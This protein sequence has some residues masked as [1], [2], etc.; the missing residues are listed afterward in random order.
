MEQQLERERSQAKAAEQK[1]ATKES[2]NAQLRERISRLYEQGQSSPVFTQVTGL[3]MFDFEVVMVNAKG[4]EVQ[5]ERK[6]AQYDTED[7]GNDI[8]LE[9]VSIPGGKFLM[10]SPEG[11]KDSNDRE[12]PQHEVTVP[13]FFMGKYLI[14]QAQWRAIAE[15]T[16]L[17]VER[18][19]DPNPSHFKGDNR[20]VE[21]VNWYEA[22]E[23]CKR[24]SKLT[25]RKYS[26]PSE[27]EWEYACRSVISYQSRS[28]ARYE[29]I[30]VTSEELTLYERNTFAETHTI[31]TSEF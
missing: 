26:L 22:D 29:A 30:S 24:L 1:L 19:L 14:T 7:L 16:N 10:G 31:H 6:Q 4:E 25:G 28:V 17:K 12:R 21:Q 5:R 2:E 11:E 27:A 3:K 9:I 20:P 13:S 18:D 23:F 15:R 8:T